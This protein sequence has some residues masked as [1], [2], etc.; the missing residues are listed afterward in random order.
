MQKAKDGRGHGRGGPPKGQPQNKGNP[1]SP[2]EFRRLWYDMTVSMTDLSQRLGINERT[3]SQRARALGFEPRTK[4]R[5]EHR[6]RFD[7]DFPAM[8][9]FGVCAKEMAAHYGV[10]ET[11]VYMRANRMGMSAR[12]RGVSRFKKARTIA[13]FR[14]FQ[15]VAKMAKSAEQESRAVKEYWAAA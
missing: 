7:A 10:G 4:L 6:T 3:V 1:I 9:I 8:W 5:G 14:A 12:G 2:A 15:L 13:D 11:A